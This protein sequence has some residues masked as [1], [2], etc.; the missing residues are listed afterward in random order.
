MSVVEPG[1]T[2]SNLVERVK[3]ILTKPSETW[4]VID[5]E[6]ATIGGIYKSYVIILAA[7]PAAIG[8]IVTL[9]FAGGLGMML[10][11]VGGGIMGAMW[12]ILSTA[13]SY[14]LS[15]AG[16]YVGALIID[17]L[18]P[19]FGA[20]KDQLKAFKVA[21]YS[22]TAVWVA[23]IAL[24]VPLL[25]GLVVIAGALYSLYLFYLGLPKLMK[26]PEE[27]AVPYFASV[28]GV[29]ILI[30]LVVALVMSPVRHLGMMGIARQA[31]ATVVIPGGKA[32]VDLGKLEAAS[33]QM[34]IAAKQMQ[35]GKGPA[36]TDPEVLK[37]LLPADIAGFGRTGVSS[38]S[39]GAGGVSGSMAEGTYTRGE[40]SFK[41]TVTDLGAAGALAGMAGAFNVNSSH[42]ESGK[43]EKIS[44]VDGRMTTESY[45]KS[46][47]HGEYGVL[48][49]DRFLV[50]AE[51]DG[52]DMGALKSAVA[53]VQPDR[54]EGLAKS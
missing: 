9:L 23:S 53:M 13:I 46:S 8:L 47:G 29:G 18:A 27:K 4:D 19:T 44:K 54:L 16:V 50:Q 52:V 30:G 7:I 43:Y 2:S 22:G 25:G 31:P 51:G 14:V 20:T 15:L 5:A 49:A 10:G 12:A 42:E 38:S 34:E 39:G 28:I 17:G 26:A 48:V 35:D 6:P 11:G 3:N 37:G 36:P 1:S 45:D 40:A 41:L 33:K 24:I 32:S 21:A